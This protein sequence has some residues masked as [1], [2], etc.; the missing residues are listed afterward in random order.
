MQSGGSGGVL[1]I[2]RR[3][4]I[5]D[6]IRVYKVIVDGIVVGSIGPPQSKSFPLLVGS[7]VLRLQIGNS[8]A[9]S[10]DVEFDLR[11]GQRCLVRTIRRGG[12]KSYMMLPLSLPE[13]A[14]A[15]AQDRPIHSRY[16]EGPWIHVS[17][18]VSGP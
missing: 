8:R 15:L 4:W 17:V 1:V 2:Q 6:A 16:Y 9:S 7:H 11:A 13:G 10:A 18:E 14:A 3:T 12:L 5:Q